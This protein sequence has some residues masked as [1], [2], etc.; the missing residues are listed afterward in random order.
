MVI[1]GRVGRQQARAQ[2]SGLEYAEEGKRV[3]TQITI[4]YL[5]GVVHGPAASHL[6]CTAQS[7]DRHVAWY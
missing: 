4:R 1:Q 2:P 3:Q 5:R 7:P 6:V